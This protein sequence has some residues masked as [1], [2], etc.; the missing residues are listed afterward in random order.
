MSSREF[1]PGRADLFVLQM[2]L[3]LGTS[4]L[5]GHLTLKS[6]YTALQMRNG[7]AVLVR[8]EQES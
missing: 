8:H 4:Q 6:C 3:P 1:F 5:L 2:I 7:M